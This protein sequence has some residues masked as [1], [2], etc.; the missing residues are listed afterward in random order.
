MEMDQTTEYDAIGGGSLVRVQLV[1]SDSTLSVCVLVLLMLV[2]C[3][4]S[5]PLCLSVVRSFV[6]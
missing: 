3:L 4:L 2:E 1:C 6:V 5:A